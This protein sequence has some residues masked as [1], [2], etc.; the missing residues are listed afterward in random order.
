MQPYAPVTDAELLAPAQ[1]MLFKLE[2]W[3]GSSWQN[4]ANKIPA[5]GLVGYWALDAGGGTLAID[6]GPNGLDGD[7]V[8][9]AAGNWVDGKFGQ[10]VLFDGAGKRVDVADNDLLDIT[11]EITV[12]CWVKATTVTAWATLVT[13]GI[14]TTW[15]S[16]HF[17][18]GLRSGRIDF[19]L[20]GDGSVLADVGDAIVAD[21][22]YHLAVVVGGIGANAIKAYI[23]GSLVKQGNRT[24]DPTPNTAVLRFG[25]DADA[26]GD[27]FDG[28]MDEIRI[29]DRA[30]TED[31]IAAIASG[32]KDSCLKSISV[33]L[34]GAGMSTTPT[35]GTWSAI[36][37]NPGGIFHPLHPTSL[38]A[39]LLRMGREVRI[40]IGARYGGVDYYWQRMIGFMD[41]PTI[42][43]G[44]HS[45]MISGM[46]YA[47]L[48]ANTALRDANEIA[49][50]ASG[51]GSTAVDA[52]INGPL[53]WGAVSVFDSVATGGAG[54]EL[55]AEADACEIGAGEADNVNNWSNG[56]AGVIS[57]EGP[58]NGSNFFLRLERETPGPDEEYADN[59]EVASV[60][61]GTRYIV[62]FDARVTGAAS[63]SG[64]YALMRTM[65]G[66]SML[67][68]VS[69]Q[70]GAWASYSIISTA[71]STGDLGL[72]LLSVG[73]FAQI[74]DVV[75]LDNISVRTYD[76]DSWFRYDMP[77]DCNGPYFVTLD[78]EP[79]GQGDQE[80]DLGWHYDEATRSLYLSE[81]MVVPNGIDNLRVYYY[82]DQVLDN[83][84]A[85]LLVWS[86][87]YPSR[88]AALADMDYVAT[89]VVL[90]RV[91]FDP[92]STALAAI[93]KL[94]ERV[95]YRFWF[96]YDGK[97]CF[98]PAPLAWAIDFAFPNW[99]DLQSLNESQDDG[100]VRNR[101]TI[102][103]SQR[104]MFQMSRDD[105][106]SDKYKAE[107]EDAVSI[108]AYREKTY[109][110]NNHLFQDQASASAMAAAVVAAFKDPK[111]YA[112]VGLFAN[113][114]PLELGDVIEFPVQL[115]PAEVAGDESDKVEV[116]VMGIIRDIKISDHKISYK[117]EKVDEL[118][119]SGSQSESPSGS[120]S[121]PASGSGS[122]SG[123]MVEE[124]LGGED[125]EEGDW[126]VPTGVSYLE[127]E[128][129]GPGGAGGARTGTV[130]GGG[131]G[132][133]AAWA[134]K[135]LAVT[136]GELLHY[137]VG[138]RGAGSPPSSVWQNYGESDET[139]VFRAA[140]G[141]DGM[142]DTGGAGGQAVDCIGDTARP[143]GDGGSTTTTDGNGAGSSAG[144][145]DDGNHASNDNR[146]GA[147]AP[148]GGGEGGDGGV[149]D[150]N[151][152]EGGYPGGGG[153][154]S[155]AVV[156]GSPAGG[157]GAGGY[158]L[159]RYWA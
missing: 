119:S 21:A 92:A 22:W 9:L 130:L 124:M 147:G 35:A 94:C 40:S 84:V 107:A 12:S 81:G 11:G 143:G 14:S 156:G 122:E 56:G 158:I 54:P 115:R 61:A 91:W 83:I 98:R 142:D 23:N 36:I 104:A 45:V 144:P 17:T 146:N 62:T 150:A 33:S 59:P 79:V 112:E 68:Q 82:T 109:A 88:A 19:R 80:R 16:N 13:K 44:D 87:L 102:E 99:G 73:K 139:E 66:S 90:G 3:D 24:G 125:Y 103:G 34:G 69:I 151:G 113:P 97:P 30:L 157:A 108:A 52:T 120:A 70:A 132:G 58:G 105:K 57:S 18:F 46:D 155:G 77:P 127:I 85:D 153:G 28:T 74:G 20:N 42:D 117:V 154:G 51:S 67:E 123:S 4:L 1:E 6:L 114:L 145:D 126:A 60:T 32:L 137:Y 47:S 37:A 106:A 134:K 138:Q 39:G 72:R 96:D 101:V 29:Y 100:M 149:P 133:G 41:A 31:K 110:I 65:Q 27:P 148:A 93:A 2:V 75:E 95:D 111:W 131:G 86:H 128:G 76:P 129:I 15:D 141:T 64:G 116:T 121:G 38:W 89:G 48:L 7:L 55:Y 25:T 5:T 43:H 118:T 63:D 53:H 136:P 135:A 8:N 26:A 140:K 10:A 71:T 152:E 78:G 49:E 50:S 159:F